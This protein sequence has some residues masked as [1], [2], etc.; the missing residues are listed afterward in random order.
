[1][2]DSRQLASEVQTILL[3]QDSLI[4]QGQAERTRIL[5]KFAAIESELG[6]LRDVIDLVARGVI[7]P[8]DAPAKAAEF[9]EN[10]DQMAVVKQALEIGLDRI[11]S[12]GVP[13]AEA[14]TAAGNPDPLTSFLMNHA[15]F[16]GTN[17]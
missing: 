15:P 13:T 5:E 14:A 9:I 6:I 12:I 3:K 11:P 17:N 1:M 4:K 2:S 10:P 7:D 16:M 8:A